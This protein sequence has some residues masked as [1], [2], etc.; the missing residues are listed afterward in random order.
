MITRDNIKEVIES[1]SI[2]DKRRIKE[3][4]KE[5]LVIYLHCFNSGSVVCITLTDN[6][7][8]YKNVSDNGHCILS[9]ED[10]LVQGLL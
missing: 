5:Y 2:R 3:T 1:I 8:K 10:E 4:S 9:M 6:Y 7:D